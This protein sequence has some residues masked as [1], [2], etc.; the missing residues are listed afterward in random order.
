MTD[1]YLNSA[2]AVV[3]DNKRIA[4]GL[5]STEAKQD[6][7]VVA[8]GLLSTEAKQDSIIAALGGADGMTVLKN[9]VVT[10]TAASATLKS[11]LAGAVYQTGVKRVSI[12]AAAAWNFNV[13][14][15]AVMGTVTL[16]GGAIHEIGCTAD[17]DLRVI[18]GSSIAALVVQEG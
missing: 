18:A 9:E 2:L 3:D 8:L 17:T 4:T 6:S 5:L 10:I 7:I 16:D 13:G 11:L 1:E 14:A 15:A 12:K